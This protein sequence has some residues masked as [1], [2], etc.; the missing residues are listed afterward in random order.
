MPQNPS[1]SASAAPGIGVGIR[2]AGTGMAV[3]DRVVTNQDLA[4]SIDTT[5]EWIVQRTG[6]HERRL[7]EPGQSMRDLARQALA[8][9]LTNA[10]LK[11]TDLEFL[12]LATCTPEMQVPN[13][14]AR[15]VA[16][17]GAAPAGAVDIN[18]ACSG[19]VY[20]L[21]LASALIK[22]GTYR[23]IGVVGAEA[24]SEL[25]DWKDRRTCILFGD[26]AGAAVLTADPDPRTGP[27]YQVMH[28]DGRQWHLIYAPRRAAHVPPGDKIFGGGFNTM[29]MNG[30]EVFK[31]AVTT[32]HAAIDQTLAAANVQAADLAM[33][34]PHQSNLRIIEAARE[35]M[36]LPPE[37][38]YVNI[39]R[40]GNTSAA[41]VPIAL[42]ELVSTGKV[43]RGDLVM[44]LALGGG[45]TWASSLW[46]V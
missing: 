24:L 8:Q 7:L 39:D 10:A 16:E 20:A 45:L 13:T 40:L 32:L 18:A 21:N 26:G 43:K 14:A 31:F 25:T 35:R 38:M 17:V 1:P 15:V 6:I 42:H 41:S 12:I 34:I 19:F 30:R 27:V 9:A 23:T 37:K 46:R 22:A 2:I 44:F 4:K 28:S 5:N 33:V 36:G 29:Q 3:P 11:P